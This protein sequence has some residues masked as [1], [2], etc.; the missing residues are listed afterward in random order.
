M[1][2][3][4]I[5]SIGTGGGPMGSNLGKTSSNPY[6][7]PGMF[8]N[9]L[10]NSAPMPNAPMQHVEQPSAMLPMGQAMNAQMT[11]QQKVSNY[12]KTGQ[13]GGK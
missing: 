5:N 6:A 4:G 1:S 11:P 3:G 13:T 2:G 10:F 9:P 12:L 7:A 8:D